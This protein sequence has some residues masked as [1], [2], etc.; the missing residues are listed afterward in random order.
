MVGGRSPVLVV[1]AERWELMLIS[2]AGYQ[3]A[4]T[5]DT[6]AGELPKSLRGCVLKSCNCTHLKSCNCTH[7]S[8]W[9]FSMYQVNEH[10]Y[11]WVLLVKLLCCHGH[12]CS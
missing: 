7:L 10:T 3:P 11:G 4:L 12:L 5:Q 1:N 8:N 6:A 9:Y 2:A